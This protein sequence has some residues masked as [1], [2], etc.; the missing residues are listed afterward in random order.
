MGKWYTLIGT[1]GYLHG[2][3]FRV[4]L[5][6][7]LQASVEDLPAIPMK[8][9]RQIRTLNIILALLILLGLVFLVVL[10]TILL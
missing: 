5:K 9:S 2:V 3:G 4:S 1:I 10:F 8:S 6:K 7:D